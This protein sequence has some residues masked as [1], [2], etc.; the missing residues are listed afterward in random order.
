M[1]LF[2]G[3]DQGESVFNSAYIYIEETRLRYL[4]KHGSRIRADTSLMGD[5][6]GNGKWRQFFD[7]L[8]YVDT[9]VKI[10]NKYI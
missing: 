5:I 1:V 9:L 4:E 3:N 6:D 7:W 2:S 8:I 10:Y